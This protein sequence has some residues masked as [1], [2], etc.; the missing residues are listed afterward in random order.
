MRERCYPQIMVDAS[1]IAVLAWLRRYSPRST[2]H[3]GFYRL[4]ENRL[5]SQPFRT[6]GEN[7]LE[8]Q[9]F[10]TLQKP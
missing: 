8:S 4:G 3:V 1:T 5:M 6:L 2:L 10:R 9:P 7:R